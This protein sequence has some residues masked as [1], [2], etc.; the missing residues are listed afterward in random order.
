MIENIDDLNNTIENNIFLKKYL[1]DLINLYEQDER[2]DSALIYK[3]N[4]KQLEIILLINQIDSEILHIIP[5]GIVYEDC[6]SKTGYELHTSLKGLDEEY[7]MWTGIIHNCNI[8]FD[9]SGKLS[10]S[11]KR[12]NKEKRLT[13]RRFLW[14][15]Y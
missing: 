13:K 5:T 7:L 12:F 1:N 11:K 6:V 10:K 2:F 8:L 3:K 4:E 14:K 9:K 15:K